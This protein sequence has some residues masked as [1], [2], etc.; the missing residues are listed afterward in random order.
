[1]LVSPTLMYRTLTCCLLV[2]V[3]EL[4]RSWCPSR[5]KLTCREVFSALLGSTTSLGPAARAGRVLDMPDSD[6]FKA[7]I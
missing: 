1:M 4:P 6:D 3:L 2:L 5:L 7:N